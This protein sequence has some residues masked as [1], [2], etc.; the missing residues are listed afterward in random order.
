MKVPRKLILNR[1]MKIDS[2]GVIERIRR[3]R[4]K[5]GEHG[6]DGDLQVANARVGIVQGDVLI[7]QGLA[8]VWEIG[9]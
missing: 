8:E 2:R 1:R 9:V 5:G 6:D 4:G 7:L 3:R